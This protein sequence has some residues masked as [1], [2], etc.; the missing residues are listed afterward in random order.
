MSHTVPFPHPEHGWEP[1]CGQCAANHALPEGAKLSPAFETM[2]KMASR[3]YELE[4][5]LLSQESAS[6][7][8]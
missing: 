5:K 8:V 3:I 1:T 2:V 7:G 6:A 4:R